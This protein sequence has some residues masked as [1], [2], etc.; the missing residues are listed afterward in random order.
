MMFGEESPQASLGCRAGC[1]GCCGFTTRTTAITVVVTWRS[2]GTGRTIWFNYLRPTRFNRASCA[3]R[4]VRVHDGKELLSTRV[5]LSDPVPVQSERFG[6]HR[7]G[8]AITWSVLSRTRS[9]ID[10]TDSR[11]VSVGT[12]TTRPIIASTTTLLLLLLL[13]R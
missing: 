11:I 1:C 3:V 6:I 5:A 10:I 8:L 13:E 12:R 4:A 9:T 2:T 7:S